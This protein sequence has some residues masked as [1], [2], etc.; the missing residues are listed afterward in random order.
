M[1]VKVIEGNSE[2]FE[3]RLNHWLYRNNNI[4]IEEIKINNKIFNKDNIVYTAIILYK[5]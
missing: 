1:K 3:D 2:I 5:E 4:S